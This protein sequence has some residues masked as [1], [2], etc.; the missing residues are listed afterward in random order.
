MTLRQPRAQARI[1]RIGPRP[2]APMKPAVRPVKLVSSNIRRVLIQITTMIAILLGAR[3]HVAAADRSVAT[4]LHLYNVGSEKQL[5]IDDLFFESSTNVA[6]RVHPPVKTGE[7]NLASD[8]PWENAMLNWFTVIQ[9]GPRYR[10]WYECYDVPGW[11]TADDTSFCYAES[12]DGV[13]WT[14]PNLG[15]FSYQGGTN[16]N[17]LFRLIGPPTANS[18]VHGTGVFIDPTAPPEARYKCVS[19]G[20]F[21]QNFDPP[22]RI[23][24]MQSPDGLRWTRHPEPICSIFADSQY[25]GFWDARLKKYVL[26]GR[27]GGRGRSLGRSESDSF[28]HFEPLQLVLQTDDQ[29]PP[30]TDLYN[31][32]P[33]RY[34][35]AANAYFMF[36][37]MYQHKPETLDIRMAVSRDG[38][39]WTW[40]ERVPF[41]PLGQAGEFDTGSLYIGQGMIR[42]GNELWQYYSGAPLRHHE[43]E[44]ENLVKPANARFFGRVVSRVDGFVSVDAG[45]AATGGFVTPPLTFTGNILKLNLVVRPGGSLRVGLRDEN[46]RIIPGYDIADCPPIGGGTDDVD[47]LVRW[48]SGGE[49]GTR[50]LKPTKLCFELKDAS[51]YAFR[52]TTGSGGP[53]RDH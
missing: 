21:E 44:L 29:D 38:V 30:D 41:I 19:Q 12:T 48:T 23:A 25:G 2:T 11:P 13:H 50:A 33:M 42:K 37:S 5:F 28:H 4:N 36:P 14:K 53:D 10:M 52:F 27:V 46:D 6:L 17:I 26:Y 32:A 8:R 3:N 34:P 35:F 49:I 20:R 51:L 39:H 31:P 9:D 47:L 18:R 43:A 16:N 7:K 40:P 15:L 45:T 24:G 1:R 22:Y